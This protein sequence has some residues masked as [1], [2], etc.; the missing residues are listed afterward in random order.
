MHRVHDVTDP[1]SRTPSPATSP[2]LQ[3]TLT[4]TG[5]HILLD[6]N[7]P[8]MRE[9]GDGDQRPNSL[10]VPM[11]GWRV[12]RLSHP[13]PALPP[14][15]PIAPLKHTLAQ[16]THVLTQIFPPALLPLSGEY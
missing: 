11:A 8:A 4:T 13:F 9:I 5:T 12:P 16:G 14:L 1:E 10:W 6:H 2:F 7:L 3:P 15:T